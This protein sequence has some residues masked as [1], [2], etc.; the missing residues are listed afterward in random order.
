MSTT[1]QELKVAVPDIGDFDD[2]PVIEILVSVG[3]EVAVED[4]LVTLE[5]D[6]ATMDVPSPAAGVVKAI[7]V[8]V[9]DRLSEGSPVLDLETSA[10]DAEQAANAPAAVAQQS[11]PRASQSPVEQA[12]QVAAEADQAPTAP[13]AP[14]AP[15]PPP[16]PPPPRTT[17]P[18]RCTRARRYAASPVSSEW[19]CMAFPAPAARV[20]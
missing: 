15:P 18:R 1:Q 4:P 9:G 5:S 2:V 19:T 10:E 14:L 16:P 8:S 13:V 3:D 7:H 20:A 17:A 6:K 12:T 11:E